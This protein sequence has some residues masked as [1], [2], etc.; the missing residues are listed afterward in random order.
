MRVD[1][2]AGLIGYLGATGRIVRTLNVRAVLTA[3]WNDDSD[4]P[5]GS[6]L[7][8]CHGSGQSHSSRARPTRRTRVVRARGQD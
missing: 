6:A 4:D 2:R 7:T 5:A 3:E 1:T 8:G